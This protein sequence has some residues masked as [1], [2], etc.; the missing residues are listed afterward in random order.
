MPKT[1]RL[2][3]TVTFNRPDADKL[4]T[5]L[6]SWRTLF[7]PSRMFE[8]RGGVNPNHRPGT[9]KTWRRKRTNKLKDGLTSLKMV[10]ALDED[11]SISRNSFLRPW[12][13]SMISPLDLDRWWPWC[14]WWSRSLEPG[15]S[16]WTSMVTVRSFVFNSAT[17]ECGIWPGLLSGVGNAESLLI[18]ES[19]EIWGGFPLKKPF[20]TI[21]KESG[22]NLDMMPLFQK[23][24]PRPSLLCL[25]F[26]RATRESSDTASRYFDTEQCNTMSQVFCVWR[27]KG[28]HMMGAAK[29][30]GLN[31]NQKVQM[32]TKYCCYIMHIWKQA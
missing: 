20:G 16:E 30:E 2:I 17:S 28:N 15:V 5:I 6:D 3:S 18:E 22:E 24:A 25:G 10:S 11:R 12:S 26:S 8:I 1:N 21:F 4:L 32:A 13:R 14:S 31:G 19:S 29:T 9:N 23:Q 27:T 7:P